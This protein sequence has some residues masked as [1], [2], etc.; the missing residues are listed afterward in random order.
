MDFHLCNIDFDQKGLLSI[1]NINGQEVY[2]LDFSD[3]S[4]KQSMDVSYLNPGVY[5]VTFTT[6]E[7]II[8]KR[9]VKN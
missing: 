5:F 8:T 7:E 3:L 1:I 9:F 2:N 6:N 4:G